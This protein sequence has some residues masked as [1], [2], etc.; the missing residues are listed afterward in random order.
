MSNDWD[1]GESIDEEESAAKQ[2]LEKLLEEKEALKKE[3]DEVEGILHDHEHRRE[4]KRRR[5]E[6]ERRREEVEKEYQK[7]VAGEERMRAMRDQR[8]TC[9]WWVLRE[10]DRFKENFTD[11]T[12]CVAVGCDGV[13]L[14]LYDAGNWAYS[15]GLP[16]NVHKLLHTRAASHPS[17]D[18]VALGSMNRYY[19]RF[20]NGKSEW[21][22]PDDLSKLLQKDSRKVKSV[23]FGEDYADYFVVFEGGGYEYVGCPPGLENKINARGKRGD[24]D[25]VTLGPDGEWSLW[26]KNGRAWW[27]GLSDALSKKISSLQR[28]GNNITDLLFGNDEYYFV[29]YSS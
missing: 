23:A 25:K 22:G 6:E 19:I 9:A 3:I 10:S 11:D 20:K 16:D 14:C 8:G 18:Y 21:V 5:K 29:R 4:E 1:D 13:Y 15:S 2:Q 27:G 12:S 24:L 7:L 28:K 26:A 17:P